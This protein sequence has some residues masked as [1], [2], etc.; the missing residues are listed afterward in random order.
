MIIL[1]PT[2]III[3]LGVSSDVRSASATGHDGGRP[4]KLARV[5]ANDALCAQRQ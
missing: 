2:H 5:V 4:T 3:V 1:N